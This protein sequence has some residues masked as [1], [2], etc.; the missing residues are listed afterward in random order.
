MNDEE[1]KIWNAINDCQPEFQKLIYN[2]LK[3]KFEDSVFKSVQELF[4]NNSLEEIACGLDYPEDTICVLSG[5]ELTLEKK[6][7]KTYDAITSA[8]HN[9]DKRTPFQYA[10]DLAAS[11]VME[12]YVINQLRDK[13]S[14][15]GLEIERAGEDKDRKMLS[16]KKISSN[17]DCTVSYGNKSRKLELVN[18]YKG[19][20][21]KNKKIDLRDDKYKNLKNDK[22]LLL[23]ISTNLKNDKSLLLGISTKAEK[24]YVLLDF[25]KDVEAKYIP[26]HFPYGGKPA[27]SISIKGMLHDLDY[28]A[29]AKAIK[30]VFH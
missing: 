25:G 4:T 1:K 2:K 11:W 20:W 19:Y 12:D 15:N 10:M 16:D 3:I 23:G 28:S 7:K 8:R 30:R 21:M 26:S 27:W 6:Y 29:I 22:S 18:D 5:D 9:R 17:S 14:K 24:K 13:L